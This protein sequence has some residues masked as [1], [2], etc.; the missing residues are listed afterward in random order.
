MLTENFTI[1]AQ[2]NIFITGRSV[3]FI[4]RKLNTF[5]NVTR[6]L[7]DPLTHSPTHICVAWSLNPVVNGSDILLQVVN[8]T[9]TIYKDTR[10]AMM[11][12]EHGV[13]LISHSTSLVT[14]TNTAR[15][16]D[17]IDL[18]YFKA[19]ECAELAQLLTNFSYVFAENPLPAGQ[20]SVVERSISTYH[21]SSNLI[22]T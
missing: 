8:I 2:S 19:E 18:S 7:L 6:G 22:T 21:R 12:P 11:V 15:A 4:T 17:Q 13:M 14:S 10:V 1:C 16:L 9:V 3:Q 20:T 5:C